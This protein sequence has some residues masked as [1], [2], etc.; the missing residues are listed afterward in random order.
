MSFNEYK[1]VKAC[2]IC[3]SKNLEQVLDMGKTPLANNLA[4][5]C[6]DSIIQQ[7]YDLCLIICK[8]CK[9][10][11]LNTEIDKEILFSKY[12][13]KTGVSSS[14]RAHFNLFVNEYNV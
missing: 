1:T 6:E 8:N 5:S 10:V 9:H 11:Q 12:S 13:Y 7:D 2:C 4:N 3:N 14:M